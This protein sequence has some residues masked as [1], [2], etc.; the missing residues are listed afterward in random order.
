[1]IKEL[2]QYDFPYA[3]RV[4]KDSFQTVADDMGL[5][6]ENC[7]RYV[8]FVTCLER[9]QTAYEWGWWM[10][11]LWQEEQ[12]IGYVAIS[13]EADYVYELHN[14][15]VLP[16]FRHRGYGKQLLA[17]CVAEIKKAG[18]DKV[19]VSIIEENERLKQWYEAYGFVSV[20]TKKYEHL[21]FTSGYL[22]LEI[23]NGN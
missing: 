4:I 3:V 6:E 15:A 13:C 16:A 23:N 17:F 20:G 10:Y 1:M 11:G 19:I 12:I 21:P 18:G 5:T 22:E 7:P 14:L 8:G 9:L 2:E